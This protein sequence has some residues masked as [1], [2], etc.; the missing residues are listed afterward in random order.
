LI[1]I[2]P[3]L[4]ILRREREEKSEV[5]RHYVLL[6][7]KLARS[8][9]EVRDNEGPIRLLERACEALPNY[10]DDLSNVIFL[11]SRLVYGKEE[12]REKIKT[13]SSLVREL[14]LPKLNK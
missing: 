12:G 7:K 10:R 14:N 4:L 3:L 2:I 9:V 1:L 11:Y 6:R 8:G 5:A 13:F